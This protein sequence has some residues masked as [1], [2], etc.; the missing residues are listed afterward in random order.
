MRTITRTIVRTFVLLLVM[1]VLMA[2]GQREQVS[3]ESNEVTVW[4]MQPGSATLQTM[5]ERFTEEF[6]AEYDASVNLVFQPWGT[7]HDAFTT[8]IATG[9]V[10]DVAEMGTTWTPEFGAIGAFAPQEIDDLSQFIEAVLESGAPEG[11][12][13]GVPW[14]AGARALIYNRTVFDE[15]GLSAPENWEDLIVAGQTIRAETDM[16]AFSVVGAGANHFVLPKV[17]QAGGEIAVQQAD[18]S[19]EATINSPEGVAAFEFYVSMFTEYGFAP[20]G[21]LN[22]TVADA[23]TAF[24]NG[25]L[26]MFL[27]LGPNYGVVTRDNDAF[28]VG[29][30]LMPAGPSGRRDT[31]AGG[32]HLVRFA[33]SRNP[34]LAQAYIDFLVQDERIAEFASEVGFFPGTVEGIEAMD[35]NEVQ[36]VFAEMLLNHSR[37]YPPNAAWGRFEGAQ[38]FT[39]AVQRMMQGSVDAQTALNEVAR[40]MNQGFAQ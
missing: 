33:G 34:D 21:A 7:A 3:E 9:D 5:L 28:E 40:E 16:Y 1:T 13:L 22:W 15:L 10:P 4:I 27:G 2:A 32:S 12:P 19:W 38:L 17:W 39:S 31:F 36:T 35:L 11:I 20:A 29:V 23:Q 6:E 18:G 24:R 8:A 25:D 37:S 14:Y 26:A 30:A